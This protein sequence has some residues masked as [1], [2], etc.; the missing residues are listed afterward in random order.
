M[1]QRLPIVLG[2]VLALCSCEEEQRL[3]SYKEEPSPEPAAQAPAMPAG[4]PPI[5][6]NAGSVATGPAARADSPI[7]PPADRVRLA[8][9]APRR[10][11]VVKGVAFTVPE[12]WT[13]TTSASAMRAAQFSLP[14]DADGRA[15]GEV[16]FFHFGPPPGG[17]SADENIKRW[18]GQ[19]EAEAPPIVYRHEA[20]GL[21]ISEVIVEGTLKPSGMGTGPTTARP[22][23][24]LYGVI[25]EGGPEGALFV[26]ATGSRSAI[27][28]AKP[29]MATMAETAK[30]AGDGM[31]P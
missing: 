8:A 21:T 17:G 22:N 15:D 30:P 26:K 20:N 31:E 13:E 3:Y 14:A 28:A 9:D 27:D 11:V 10:E 18:V 29:G 5:S 6:A 16:V 7:P 2:A 4:H 1:R 23:S 12:A 25:V 19:V 24:S